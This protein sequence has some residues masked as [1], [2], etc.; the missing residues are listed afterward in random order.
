MWG[1]YAQHLNDR[2]AFRGSV[3]WAGGVFSQVFS[4][5]WE[6]A[7]ESLRGLFSF[8][9]V[10]GISYFQAP[11]LDLWCRDPLGLRTL[12]QAGLR[13]SEMQIFTL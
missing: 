6:R 13:P 9:P 12:S 3:L 5:G 4:V 7:L 8:P 2:V 10:G 1:N 11:V